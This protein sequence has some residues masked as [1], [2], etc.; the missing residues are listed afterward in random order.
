MLAVIQDER[1][2]GGRKLDVRIGIHCGPATAGVIGDTR[3]S[4][5]VWGDAV[6][7]AARMESHGLPGR[8][9]VSE[10][11][12]DLT[13]EVFS[14]DERGV[15]EIKSIGTTKRSSWLERKIGAASLIGALAHGIISTEIVGR[16]TIGIGQRRIAPD[17]LDVNLRNALRALTGIVVFTQRWVAGG[18]RAVVNGGVTSG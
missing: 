6:N 16:K 11:F 1:P 2:L 17:N 10:A 3:F 15:T 13:K 9:Q 12:R 4:Y 18:I 7:F 5:D 8:I 14:F